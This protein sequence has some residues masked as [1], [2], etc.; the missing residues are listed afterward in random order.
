MNDR[1]NRDQTKGMANSKTKPF[2]MRPAHGTGTEG[3][4]PAALDDVRGRIKKGA[5]MSARKAP[6][7]R[8]SVGETDATANGVRLSLGAPEGNTVFHDASKTIETVMMKRW[9]STAG[10]RCVARVPGSVTSARTNAA[11]RPCQS[12]IRATN[13][14]TSQT[15]GLGEVMHSRHLFGLGDV[16]GEMRLLPR[17][18]LNLECALA[19]FVTQAHADQDRIA[20]LEVRKEVKLILR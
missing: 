8:Q 15:P 16:Y 14:T 1:L 20:K 10:M 2:L 4:T 3:G 18:G 9:P 13:V 7:A 19:L 5:S 12:P 11:W 6:D 17:N